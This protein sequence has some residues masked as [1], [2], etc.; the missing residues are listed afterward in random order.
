MATLEQIQARLKKLQAQAEAIV[1]KQ[2][3]AALETIRGL[4]ERHGLTTSDIDTHHGSKKREPKAGA[5]PAVKAA[6]SVAKYRNP[7]SGATWSGRGRAPGWIANVKDRSKFLVGSSASSAAPVPTTKAK[8]AGNY[9]RGPQPA[10]YRDPKSGA[11]WSGRGPAPAWLSGAKDRTK[12]LTDG[13]A[14]G[15]SDAGSISKANT[16]KAAGKK[17]AV[18]KTAAAP[19]KHST[20]T[21]VAAKKAVSTNAGGVA[22]PDAAVVLRA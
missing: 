17:V 18:K 15:A 16:R 13:G 11:T 5:K 10:K 21:K 19:A 3:S 6:Q 8:A 20:V 2:S 1:A 22:V 14:A 12:F 4:M 7:K 9:V